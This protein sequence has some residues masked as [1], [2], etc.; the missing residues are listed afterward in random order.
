MLFKELKVIYRCWVVCDFI[1]QEVVKQANSPFEEL[2]VP[3][4]IPDLDE[5]S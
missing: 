3:E 1:E 5:S 2:P 4:T